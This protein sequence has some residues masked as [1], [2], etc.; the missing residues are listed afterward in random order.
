[1]VGQI[2][3]LTQLEVNTPLAST[4]HRSQGSNMAFVATLEKAGDV[5]SYAE[6]PAHLKYVHCTAVLLVDH[7]VCN[8]C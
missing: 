1:M 4:A 7:V 5:K 2:P 6:H 8:S 3:G